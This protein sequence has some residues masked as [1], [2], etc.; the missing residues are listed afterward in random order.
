MME[1]DPPVQD[2]TIVEGQ[3]LYLHFF[4]EQLRKAGIEN[5]IANQQEEGY[6]F[7]FNR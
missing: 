4:H 2:D 6:V 5:Q 7:L 1:E 3:E